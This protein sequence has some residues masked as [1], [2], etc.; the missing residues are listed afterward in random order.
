MP[1]AVSNKDFED[2]FANSLNFYQA[3]AGDKHTFTCEILEQISVFDSPVDYLSY[4]P[5]T[6]Q[7]TWSGGN[8]LTEGFQVGDEIAVIVYNSNGNV[9]ATTLV[10]VLVVEASYIIVDAHVHGK[11]AVNT[12]R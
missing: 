3:N 6:N 12:L 11:V 2:M 10:D 9:H 5:G 4:T 7:I 1:I 8:F